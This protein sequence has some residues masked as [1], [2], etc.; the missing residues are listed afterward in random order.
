MF[1]VEHLSWMFHVEQSCLCY[2]KRRVEPVPH[3]LGFQAQ[4]NEKDYHIGLFED[5]V[6][7]IIA[8]V[9]QK[10][11]VGKTTTAV[12]LAAALAI[13]ERP[14]LLIDADPQANST[15][16]LGFAAD[17]DRASLY[18]AITDAIPL[19]DLKL[20]SPDLPKLSLI[21]ADSNLVGCEVELIEAEGREYRLKN[22][23]EANRDRYREFLIDCPPS[24]NLLTLNALTA[25]D[26]VLI[27]VQCEYLAL[28]GISQ[29]LETI[30]LVSEGLNPNL[31]I[32]GVVMTMYDERTN[33][34][35]Q[36]VDEVRE[37]LG[38]QVYRTVIPRNIRLGEAPSH[39]KPIFLY[40]IRSKGSKAYFDLAKEFVHETKGTGKRVAQP[41]SRGAADSNDAATGAVEDQRQHPEAAG[42]RPHRPEPG[43][44]S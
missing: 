43:A 36:V 19:E 9:N 12:N 4:K 11:G 40:D 16:S 32:R 30:A 2:I 28:E 3:D 5:R 20:T 44:T 27:P 25:A 10:G 8:V 39:G 34:S 26:G 14:V 42:H 13:A 24:L 38:D 33:L 37:V 29:L 7:K 18:D 22:L 1:H 21:P 41:H 23:L 6:G 31:A 35:R 15:R 17:P